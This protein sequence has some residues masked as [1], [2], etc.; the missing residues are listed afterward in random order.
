MAH[1]FRLAESISP[2]MLLDVSR[3]KTTSTGLP[4]SAAIGAA[5]SVVER[6]RTVAVAMKSPRMAG[7]RSDIR[8]SAPLG[9][10]AILTPTDRGTRNGTVTHERSVICGRLDLH[11]PQI[12]HD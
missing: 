8:A 10:V 11:R 4:F 3:H 12:T 6:L 1:S 9:S 5:V 2:S 7:L